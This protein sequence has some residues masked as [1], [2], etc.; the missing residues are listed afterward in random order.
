MSIDSRG[1]LWTL[2]TSSWAVQFSRY[3]LSFIE[4][5]WKLRSVENVVE[6]TFVCRRRRHDSEPNQ[7]GRL[8]GR[9]PA[10]A[11]ERFTSI[12]WT[13]LV[14]WQMRINFEHAF[15]DFSTRRFFPYL[16]MKC[17]VEHWKV[18]LNYELLD[19]LHVIHVE[20]LAYNQSGSC[21]RECTGEP[22]ICY[23]KFKLENFNVMGGYVRPMA[24]WHRNLANVFWS[25]CT[26]LAVLAVTV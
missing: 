22:F 1:V 7:R 23:F 4:G 9:A 17:L 20:H 19:L 21:Y 18:A 13:R 11:S 5:A 26:M 2:S 15:F 6:A 8:R 3:S 10:N 25:F 16:L 14:G 24:Y 12:I